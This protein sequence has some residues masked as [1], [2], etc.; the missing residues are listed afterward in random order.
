MFK[1][2]NNSLGLFLHHFIVVLLI[3]MAWFNNVQAQDDD[4]KLALVLSG[5]AAHGLAHIG[6][7]RYLEE[8]GIRPDFITGTSMGAVIG[9]LYALGYNSYQIEAIAAHQDWD[10]LMSNRTALTDIAPIEKRYHDRIPL[11]LYWRN[12]R[13]KLPA[14]LISGQLLDINLSGLFID[15]YSIDDFD[16][17]AIPFRCVAIDIEDGSIDVFK[18]GYLADAIR[19]SMAI[20]SVFPPKEINGISYV[21]GGLLRNFPVEEARE[22][23]A[24]KVIGVY[25]GGI[26]L[27]KDE[28]NSVLDILEQSAFMAGILDSENQALQSDV[29]IRPDVKQMGKFDFSDYNTFIEKGYAAAQNQ[30]SLLREYA[31]ESDLSFYLDK[32]VSSSEPT[33]EVDHMLITNAHQLV[34]KFVKQKLRFDPDEPIRLSDLEKSLSLV[35]GTKNFSKTSY[36]FEKNDSSVVLKLNADDAAPYHIGISL[37]R[38][39]HYNSALILNAEARNQLGRLS[40]LRLDTRISEH[41]GI[42]LQYYNRLAS[43]PSYIFGVYAKAESFDLPF[44]HNDVVDRLYNY[45]QAV[46]GIEFN[47]EWNNEF[48]FKASFHRQ[49]DRIKPEVFKTDDV[50]LYRSLRN[51]ISLLMNVNTLNNQVF[52]IKGMSAEISTSYVFDNR[53]SREGQSMS[54]EFLNNAEPNNYFRADL[55]WAVYQSL[56]SYWCIEWLGNARISSEQSFMDHYRVGGPFQNKENNYGFTG[57]EESELLIGDHIMSGLGIRYDIRDMLYMTLQFQYLYGQDYLSFAFDRSDNISVWGY[58]IRLGL[59]S[60]I[61]PIFLDF[62]FTNASSDPNLNLGVGFRHIY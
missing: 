25:V 54:T 11:N 32:T 19:A 45:R 4:Q 6:V 18:D 33:V 55:Q 12:D 51:R 43:A 20:P 10:K 30:D 41:P 60:P 57:L 29:L 14:G 13:F 39:R 49:F 38:F 35:Y 28:L 3:S 17:L 21:D 48:L 31:S 47:K 40:N 23:G 22:L 27:Q 8:Q 56:N 34:R 58:G 44:I 62:G 53:I 7:I 2:T 50:K 15:A 59:D 1:S 61:G 26:K 24:T 46:L 5:G 16:Q 42:Q 36:S 9:G 37:N 52:P